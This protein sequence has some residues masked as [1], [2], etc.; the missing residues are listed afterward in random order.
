MFTYLLTYFIAKIVELY[1]SSE[2]WS[3]V[4]VSSELKVSSESDRS[5]VKVSSELRS[6]VKVSSQSRE[7]QFRAQELCESQVPNMSGH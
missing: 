1:S 5:R 2:L 7:S 6:R 3:R 4:K